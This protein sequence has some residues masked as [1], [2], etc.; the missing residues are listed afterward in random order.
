MGAQ[1]KPRND[2]AIAEETPPV[3][4]TKRRR[5]GH[6]HGRPE[7]K[8]VAFP[9][10]SF[11]LH[12]KQGRAIQSLA[13]EILYG[14]AAGGGKS[15]LFRVAA[16]SWCRAIPGL[17]VYLFRRSLP[18]LFKNHM[19][20]PA[21]FPALL[22]DWVQDKYCRI[23]YG[24]TPRIEF[25]N[26]SVIHLCHCLHAKHV[27]NYQ[28]AEI[29]VLI[30]D[31]LT[32]W[33]AP[34][35]YYLRGRVRIGG[36]KVPGDLK[37]LF[38]RILVGANPGG[39][40]H[41]WVKV[42]FIDVAPPLTI[43]KM[44]KQDGGM[45]RQYV[46]ARLEDNPTLLENDPDYEDRLHGL[47]DQA[48]VRAM[49]EGD[50]DIVAGGMVDDL[51]RRD[52]HVIQRF[53]IPSSW[54]IDRSF[55]WGSSKPFSVGWWAESDGTDIVFPDGSRRSTRRGDL[56]RIA[57]WYG[58]NEKPNEGCRMLASDIAKGIVER[59]K[60]LGIHDRVKPGPADSAIYDVENGNCI[61]DDMRNAKDARVTWIRAD[62]GPGSRKQ[63]WEALRKRLAA[64]RKP[65]S[66]RDEPG[67]WIFENCKHF[68]RSVPVLPR[69]D[70][71]P[72]DV[73][74]DAEDHVADE[75]R[76]RIFTARPAAGVLK[77]KGT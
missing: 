42:D 51:W 70:K 14:G 16:I 24:N 28:G 17:Q 61:A 74:T 10:K 47:G 36:L 41:A 68:I 69:S 8:Q 64:A 67:L 46:P 56:Y 38:P 5:K 18:D 39:I 49:R 2:D 33:L 73:D 22:A 40:G 26:G 32:Q 4:V 45:R 58:W 65:L 48:L 37:G 59:E 23:L 1:P 19:E 31:E 75:T 30:I 53:P 57:E 62:K 7:P 35:Y 66:E 12:R 63:G 52:V 6:D 77:V 55:D 54:R 15:H 71:D 3:I 20:G 34:M 29:H 21:G 44:P 9:K 76:Y 27:Y 72:D 13:T 11:K 25:A 50:W 43:T 60:A